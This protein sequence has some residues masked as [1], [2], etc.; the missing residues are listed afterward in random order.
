MNAANATPKPT[1]RSVADTA[2]RLAQLST[3][4][5]WLPSDLQPRTLET[6]SA[7]AAPA[8]GP[9]P[10]LRP[11]GLPRSPERT[12]AGG[13]HKDTGPRRRM[14]MSIP[15]VQTPCTVA[16]DGERVA[17]TDHQEAAHAEVPGRGELHRRRRQGSTERRR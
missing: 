8:M 14:P 12:R 15:A 10:L 17:S 5:T 3:G 2:R 1:R 13:P 9:D 4:L 7:G 16:L 6:H 11:R